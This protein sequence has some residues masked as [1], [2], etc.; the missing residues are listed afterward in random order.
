MDDHGFDLL[1]AVRQVVMSQGFMQLVGAEVEAVDEG[2]CVLAVDRRDELL[3]QNGLIHGGVIAFLV[4]NATTAAAGT[5]VRPGHVVLT[6][7]YK[8]NLLAPARGDRIVC[9][10]TVIK[11]GRLLTVVEA[12]VRSREAGRDRD[13]A[14]ALATI[15]NVPLKRDAA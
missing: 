8:L 13:V 7:E 6:A 4:D 1:A 2:R 5:V 10:A 11:P 9:E 12:R 3:Q 14:Q 15:A